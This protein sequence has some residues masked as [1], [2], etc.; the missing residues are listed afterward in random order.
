MRAK[1]C[2][3]Q[4]DKFEFCNLQRAICIP[5]RGF[6]LLE[7]IVVLFLISLI[8]GIAL[9]FFANFLPSNRLDATVRNISST[10]KHAR[11]LARINNRIQIVTI[12]LDTKQY[13]I[14]GREIKDIPADIGVKVIDPMSGE[15][16]QGKYRFLLHVAGNIEG[17]TIIV[18]NA[19]KSISIQPDPIV[20]TVIIK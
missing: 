20:G 18:W 19:K 12:D 1:R 11:S 6:I 9:I 13:G 8:M 15:I 17:G 4:N 3:M 7:L 10:I 5:R 2:K 16:F 14:E